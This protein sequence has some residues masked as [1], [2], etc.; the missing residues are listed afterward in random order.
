MG[1]VLKGSELGWEKGEAEERPCLR[2]KRNA[3]L[4]EG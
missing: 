4:K 2:C 1:M 3:R